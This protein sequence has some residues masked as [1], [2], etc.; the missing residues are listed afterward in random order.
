VLVAPSPKDHVRDE[1]GELPD[2]DSSVNCT[3]SGAGPLRGEPWKVA[4]GGR[5]LVS[6]TMMKSVCVLVLVPAAVVTA[7]ETEYRPALE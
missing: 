1:I 4:V 5:M 7:S 2:V 6:D 3:V